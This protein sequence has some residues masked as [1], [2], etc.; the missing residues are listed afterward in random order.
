[1]EAQSLEALFEEKGVPDHVTYGVGGNYAFWTKPAR[2]G[3]VAFARKAKGGL[4]LVTKRLIGEGTDHQH[5][6][7]ETL[8]LPWHAIGSIEWRESDMRVEDIPF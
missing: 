7:T 4:A 2:E 8:F 6:N 3:E 5:T 1:M